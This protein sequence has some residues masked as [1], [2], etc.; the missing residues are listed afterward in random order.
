MLHMQARGQTRGTH[1]PD[2]GE[3]AHLNIPAHGDAL[4]PDD[5]QALS[6]RA[7]LAGI[8]CLAHSRG[9]LLLVGVTLQP[10]MISRLMVHS[11]FGMSAF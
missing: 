2:A 6:I 8:Q 9:E 1:L 5:I 11:P 7:D 4:G 10:R 3:L